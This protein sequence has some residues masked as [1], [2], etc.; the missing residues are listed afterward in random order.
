[1]TGKPD[2][3]SQSL[4]TAPFDPIQAFSPDD[5]VRGMAPRGAAKEILEFHLERAYA[6]SLRNE[7]RRKWRW[8]AMLH[9]E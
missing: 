8:R 3:T 7:Y 5:I 4:L 1:M 2:L 6:R 9:I